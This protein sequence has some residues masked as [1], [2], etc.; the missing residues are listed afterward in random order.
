MSSDAKV[1]LTFHIFDD[2]VNPKE[3]RMEIEIFRGGEEKLEIQFYFADIE[4]DSGRQVARRSFAVH[5]TGHRFE[6]RVIQ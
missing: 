1:Q 2:S 6:I 4:S 5:S 3:T